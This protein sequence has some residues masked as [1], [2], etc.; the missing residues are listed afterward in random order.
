M[1]RILFAWELGANL[2]HLSRDVP[3]AEKLREAGH[4]VVFAVRDTRIAAEILMPRQFAFL[5]SP[6]FVGRARLAKPPANYAELLAAEGWCDRATLIGHLRAW[7]HTLTLGAFDAVVADHA[8]GALIAARIA[9]CVG[10]AFGSGFEIPPD[11]EPMPTIR[12]WERYSADRLMISQRKVLDDINAAVS[13]LGGGGYSRLGEV[14]SATPILAT[15]GEL[16]PYGQRGGA[17]YV[18]SIHGISDVPEVPWP[19][20]DGRRVVVYLRSHHQATAVVMTVLA[21]CAVSAICLIPGVDAN[22]KARFGSKSL[23]IVECPA[24][25]GPLLEN[26]DAMVGAASLGSM[27]Y[28]MLMG[29]PLLM[30]PTTVEQYLHAKRA[31]AIGVGIL[32]DGKADKGRIREA[33]ASLCSEV[34]FKDD[35]KAFAARYARV[36]PERAASAAARHVIELISQE[37]VL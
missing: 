32:I 25:L 33:I 4:E 34:R 19:T 21:E 30:I 9:G 15:F 24:A 37:E 10:I 18:G 8:P 20:G 28:A 14:F 7:L 12:S 6:M 27:T 5:Q 11:V 17:R 2:G 23:S 35:A 22:F 29:V 16:D 36:T 26:A 13:D 1:S 3:V 31:E